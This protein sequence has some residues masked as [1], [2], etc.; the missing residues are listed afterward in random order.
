[1]IILIQSHL[2]LHIL[3]A[4]LIICLIFPGSCLHY[5]EEQSSMGDRKTFLKDSYNYF[6][7]KLDNT[8]WAGALTLAWH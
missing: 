4:L 5:H 7:T 8:V 6:V 3:I 1:M 2:K